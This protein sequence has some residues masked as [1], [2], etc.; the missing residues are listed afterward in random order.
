MVI[1][2]NIPALTT[3]G[4][5][6]NTSNALEKSIQ[7]L[8]T[9]LRINSAADDAAGLSISE[10]MRAQI[11]GLDRAVANA[12]DGVSLIQTAEGALTETH[13][14]LQR[15]R[16]LSVQAAN[17]TLTQQDRSYIQEEVDLLRDEIDHIGNT[18]TFNTKK[19]LNGDA[20]VL[21]SSDNLNTKALVCGG[22]REVDQF[23]QKKSFEGNFKISITADPGTAEVQKSD[24]MQVK[25]PQVGG[26]YTIAS[27]VTTEVSSIEGSNLTDLPNDGV[28]TVKTVGT[29]PDIAARNNTTASGGLL[30][31][32]ASDFFTSDDT[33][34]SYSLAF[35]ITDIVDNSSDSTKA[36]TATVHVT[37]FKTAVDG[38]IEEIN[39]DIT[40]TTAANGTAGG[41]ADVDGG[42]AKIKGSVITDTNFQASKVGDKA[43]YNIGKTQ[44]MGLQA[45]FTGSDGVTQTH[46]ANLDTALVAKNGSMTMKF[47]N[48]NKDT[49]SITK[50]SVTVNFGDDSGFTAAN[51]T[52]GA[53]LGTVRNYKIGEAAGSNV[54]LRDLSKFWDS[55]GNFM[56][57]DPQTITINQGNGKTA[58][59][60]LY[61]HDTLKDVEDKLNDA[62]AN[63][64]GQAQ[65]VENTG[66]GANLVKASDHFVDYVDINDGG[67]A[68]DNAKA[69]DKTSE[70]VNGTFVIRSA[71]AGSAGTLRFATKNEDLLNAL[72]LNTLT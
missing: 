31:L 62:I 43:V 15:M 55:Q 19:L 2:H 21:W 23:G 1:N 34:Y 32:D 46:T 67:T 41:D 16:E 70:S 48:L 35:E 64:L 17:D 38:T 26:R 45:T 36:S 12:Q 66:T 8:S 39:E 58:S 59:V 65:Y 5:V 72:S 49:G 51:V 9:G 42:A 61:G 29:G 50:E 18:T 30:A 53:T 63:G 13:S 28:Y 6:N 7:K 57:D 14:I 3:Y 68:N 27:A 4:I 37:G 22:L 71:V 25:H 24:I 33:D 60:T 52:G 10:K 69:M 47:V 44:G 40:L 54:K 56:L 20:A 11:G